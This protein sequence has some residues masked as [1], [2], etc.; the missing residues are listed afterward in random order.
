VRLPTQFKISK[1]AGAAASALRPTLSGTWARRE[2]VKVQRY[3]PVSGIKSEKRQVEEEHLVLYA[4]DSYVF[5]RVDTGMIEPEGDVEGPI[6]LEALKHMERGVVVKLGEK[7]I[8]TGITHY[9]RVLAERLGY[10][11]NRKEKPY[12]QER[13]EE[14]SPA[15]A[16]EPFRVAIGPDVIG[17]AA[18]AM[19]ASG[20][21]GPGLEL[22]FDMAEAIGL[23]KAK[24]Y[25]KPIRI[26]PLG[27]GQL[28]TVSAEGILMPIRIN[29]GP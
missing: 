10:E 8:V 28:G 26:R 20:K 21:S 16:K 14:L 7:E 1:I 6:P 9:D 3:V 24:T 12:P 17:R 22:E 29:E 15:R 23:G 25:L 2:K 19:G 18:A 11:E 13:W 5:V 27:G 4:T